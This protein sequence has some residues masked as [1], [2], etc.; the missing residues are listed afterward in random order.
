[1]EG[2]DG[3]DGGDVKPRPFE[4]YAIAERLGGWTG[5]AIA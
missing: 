4:G 3:V 5:E 1:M 2:I